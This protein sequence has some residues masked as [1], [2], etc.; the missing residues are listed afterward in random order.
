MTDN[1]YREA[2]ESVLNLPERLPYNDDPNA[3]SPDPLDGYTAEEAYERGVA[4][5]KSAI[6]AALGGS[7]EP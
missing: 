6:E 3:W 1:K 7:D 4:D 2:V 5:A